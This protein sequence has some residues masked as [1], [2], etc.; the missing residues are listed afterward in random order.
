MK[1]IG[2]MIAVL[3]ALCILVNTVYAAD[4]YPAPAAPAATAPAAAAPAAPA[5]PA[6]EEPKVTGNVGLG[7]FNKYI[8]R[9]YE[10]SNKSAVFQPTA[11]VSYRG[12]SLTFWGNLDSRQH[13][14]ENFAPNDRQ[15][16][17]NETDLTASYTYNIGKLGLTAGYI[18]YGTRYAK[19]TQ[20]VFGSATY[21]IIA[22]PTFTVNQDIAAYKGTYFNLAFSQS[23]PVFKLPTGDLTLDLGASFGYFIGEANY[24]KT[25]DSH[26][27]QYDGKKYNAAHDGMGKIGFTVPLGKGFTIQP[28]AQYWFPL[29]GDAHKK[30]ITDAAGN[31]H[32]WQQNGKVDN[33]FVYGMNLGFAF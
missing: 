3:F 30:Q 16:S 24:W 31:Q 33:T 11:T 12:F 28:V 7:A 17:W 9:G 20:E 1:K 4:P 14:T 8:F 15:R 27:G 18:Y 25:F 23:Q 21:D 5:A 13:A 19:E 10:L 26:T 32:N 2:L 22:H 29:S 6:V